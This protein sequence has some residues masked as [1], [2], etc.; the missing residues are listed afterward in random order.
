M[1]DSTA[2]RFSELAEALRGEPGVQLP[3]AEASG[4]KKFGAD[5]L[6]VDGKIFAMV[7]QDR[8]VVKLA[9]RRVDA[10]VAAG[11]GIRFDPGHGR[12]MKEWLSLEPGSGLDWLALARE[13]LAYVGPSS[14]HT[15]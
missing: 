4:K 7:S 13:A 3:A 5:A 9:R 10:L 14:A 2:L 15:A 11:E 1:I 12:V 8:F 6:K